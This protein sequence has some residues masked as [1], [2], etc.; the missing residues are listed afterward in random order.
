MIVPMLVQDLTDPKLSESTL[1]EIRVQAL[2]DNNNVAFRIEWEDSTQD[3]VETHKQFSDAAAVQL[4]P[5]P[6]GTVPDPTMGQADKPVHIQL[7]KASYEGG[8]SLDDWSLQQTFPN[9]TVDHYPFEADQ[10]VYYSA[11][12]GESADPGAGKQRG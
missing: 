10:A 8:G 6:G 9:A 1:R 11:C 5:A 2:S 7:W 4:P 12:G 3:T